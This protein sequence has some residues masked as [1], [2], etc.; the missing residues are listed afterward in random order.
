M[1]DEGSLG[2]AAAKNN[3]EAQSAVGVREKLSGRL[4]PKN[5][6][7]VGEPGDRKIYIEDYVYTYLSKMAQPGNLY[8]RGAVLFGRPYQTA[9]GICLF[10]SGA[11]SCQSIEFDLN[12]TVF[13]EEVWNEIYR[14]RDSYF[15]E[16]EVCGWFLSRMGFS[17]DLNDKIIRMHI[18]NF[19]GEHKVLYMMDVLEDEDAFYRME[20]YSLKKQR[21]YY[22]YYEANHEMAE[23]MQEEGHGETSRESGRARP[24]LIRDSSVVKSYKNA[25]QLKKSDKKKKKTGVRWTAS[26]VA[27][28]AVIAM[29]LIY[30]IYSVYQ[31]RRGEEMLSVFGRQENQASYEEGSGQ[32]DDDIIGNEGEGRASDEA[33]GGDVEEDRDSDE[34]AGEDVEEDD[35]AGE[36]V[37]DDQADGN[38]AGVDQSDDQADAGETDVPE[39]MDVFTQED[40]DDLVESWSYIGGQYTVKQGDTLASI[41]RDIYQSYD[42]I[43]K[44]ADENGIEDI[45]RIYPGQVLKIPLIDD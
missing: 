25:M 31:F 2:Q 44:I 4:L 37:R 43:Q 28:A 19:S 6:R 23:Y 35:S 27:G 5:Y 15:P 7:Q 1:A 13:S 17:V 10:I 12:E 11:A 45:N 22:I 21:G 3:G 18:D 16:L 38:S 36:N 26:S 20:N 14:I 41:S 8:S 33:A 40:P 39:D 24:E 34:A 32:G 42:Y 9:S 30:G 29:A